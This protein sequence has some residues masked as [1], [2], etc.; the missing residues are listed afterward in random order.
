[1]KEPREDDERLSALLEGRVEGRQR[2]ELLAHLAEA[3][4]DYE[5]FTNTASVLRALEEE[6]ARARR[7]VAV[8]SMRRRGWPSARTIAAVAGTVVLL[9][10]AGWLL[11]GRGGTAADYPLRLA[12]DVETADWSPWTPQGT[13]RGGDE[14]SSRDARAVYAGARLVDLAV[15]VRMG[16]TAQIGELALTLQR[17]LYRNTNTEAPLSRIAAEPTAPA[18]S[19]NALVNEATKDYPKRGRDALELGA[20][21][22]AARLAARA[23]NADFF[24]DGPTAG[25]L[26]R[27]ERLARGDALAEA[28]V[29][30]VDEARP[31]NGEANWAVLASRLEMMLARLAHT[32][33]PAPGA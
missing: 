1:V 32:G 17:E 31:R 13:V 2:E 23:R 26:R 16:N 6:D 25:M 12:M 19:L 7:P 3:D 30:A 4:D 21:I 5:V 11:R 33:V 29:V 28:A 20:W 24:E 14:P 22:E 9:L 27:A 15:F 10:A 18:A 8:L